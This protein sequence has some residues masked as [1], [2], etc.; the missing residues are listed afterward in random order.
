MIGHLF[1]LIWNRRRTNGLILVELFSC[2]LVLCAVLTIA[3]NYLISTTQPLGYDYEDVWYLDLDTP[4]FRSMDDEQ[5]AAAWATSDQLELMLDGMEE[6]E[7]WSPLNWNVPFGN[8]QSGYSNYIN[9]TS[10]FIWRNSVLPSMMD[11]LRLE[12]LS[13]R[14]LEPGDEALNYEPVVLTR[15]YARVLFGDEDPIGR[16][17]L[18]YEE[19]GSVR[20]DEEGEQPVQ[21]VVGVV[22]DMRMRGEMGPYSFCHFNPRETRDEEYS[23]P[24]RCYLL[25]LQPG[26]TAA[27]EED[28]VEGVRRLAPSWIVNVR[29]LSV[30]RETR[31]RDRLLQLALMAVIAVFLI[32]M[33]GLGL[34]GVLWQSVTRR[35]REWGLRRAVGAPGGEVRLQ[36]LGELLALTTVAASAGAL[37]FIQLPFFQA[38]PSVPWST[39][40][41]GLVISLLGMYLFV[42]V[43]GLYPSW[44]ATRVQPAEALQYE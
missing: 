41:L 40:L 13:G 30:M 29:T 18:V 26:T 23:S 14:W 22:S 9:G 2:F 37:V 1:K 43:C 11:V 12:L 24:A 19:D 31:L 27:F 32:I 42:I 4:T 3:C 16:E 28:L 35:T 25:R 15:N 8:S 34:V 20:E 10:E 38:F 7:A 17:V 5:K 6:V 44:L 36:V 33:V 21:R 39:Y